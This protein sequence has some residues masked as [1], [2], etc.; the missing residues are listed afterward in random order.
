M[1]NA[2]SG[3]LFSPARLPHRTW[4]GA[5]ALW[6]GLTLSAC[7][8]VAPAERPFDIAGASLEDIQ[9]GVR[10][11][12]RSCQSLVDFYRRRY[13]AQNPGLRAL[14]TWNAR[15]ATAAAVLDAVPQRLRGPFHCVP[16]VVKDNMDV[17]GL[18]TTA[19]ARA[20]SSSIPKRSAEVVSRLVDAG[21]IVLAKSNMPDFA[22]DGINTL[23]SLGGQTVNPYNTALTVYGSSGGS[24]AAI[25]ANLGVIGLGS[26]TFG[27]LVQPASATGLVTIRPTQGL[28]PVAGILPLMTLQD[29]PGPMTRTVEEAAATLELLAR[30]PAGAAPYTQALRGEGL[31]G[32]KIGTDPLLLAPLPMPPLSPSPEVIELFNASLQDLARGGAAVQQV[33]ALQALFPAIQAVTDLSFQC[34]P[35]DFKQ[36]INEY[37]QSLGPDAPRKSLAEIIATGAGSGY[38]DSVAGFLANAQ[39]ATETRAGATCQG[40]LAAKAAA[41]QAITA[42]MDQQGLDLLVYPAANQPP[43]AAGA[44]P[45]SGWYGFQALSSPTGLPSLSMPMGV[46]PSSGAPVG[47]I[48]LARAGQEAKLLQAAYGFQVNRA[49][50]IPPPK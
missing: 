30:R 26:D 17:A 25:A 45:P 48:F 24:A 13:E 16:L 23:S 36:G 47:L 12:Q 43:F 29:M 7:G 49:R 46:A 40:Y 31:R 35:I 3:S 34:M 39:A 4:R 9:R 1:L 33:S 10:G 19:G 14:T 42:F 22:L 20:L 2:K 41:R 38:L 8:E 50:R 27:S 21:A 28:I 37:L 5:A 6:L 11:G 32:L 44:A 18:P 15:A